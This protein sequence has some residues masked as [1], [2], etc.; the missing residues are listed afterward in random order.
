MN[1]AVAWTANCFYVGKDPPDEMEEVVFGK[2]TVSEEGVT[3]RE[4]TRT[5]SPFTKQAEGDSATDAFRLSM[6]FELINGF[7]SDIN[8]TQLSRVFFSPEWWGSL[9]WFVLFVPLLLYKV[10]VDFLFEVTGQGMSG[11]QLSIGIGPEDDP[12]AEIYFFAIHENKA[13][14][15]QIRSL[16]IA[17]RFGELPDK[18]ITHTSRIETTGDY[19]V[20]KTSTLLIAKGTLTSLDELGTMESICSLAEIAALGVEWVDEKTAK[21]RVYQNGLRAADGLEELSELSFARSLSEAIVAAKLRPNESVIRS[22]E[23]KE[24]RRRSKVTPWFLYLTNTRLIFPGAERFFLPLE[25]T[26]LTGYR[27]KLEIQFDGRRYVPH[28]PGSELSPLQS[29][30]GFSFVEAF[31][32]AR[33]A[34]AD[35]S[36][37]DGRGSEASECN[38]NSTQT[39]VHTLL[40]D[41]SHGDQSYLFGD[42]VK[43]LFTR[44]E[45]VANFGSPITREILCT[46]DA[47]VLIGPDKQ[48]HVDEV[49]SVSDYVEGGGILVLITLH[50]G[51]PENINR[52]LEPYQISIGDIKMDHE[53][54]DKESSYSDFLGPEGAPIL[55]VGNFFGAGFTTVST[56]GDADALL[57]L[58]Q[59][60]DPIIVRKSHGRGLVLV[61][62]CA[63]MFGNKQLRYLGN[64]EVLNW[65]MV[66]F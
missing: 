21:I 13:A 29:E 66:W 46:G 23:V 51:K 27:D 28:P 25:R 26:E 10:A 9:W 48:W 50:G 43:R 58:S 3:F 2:L 30:D 19:S 56:K 65:L 55:S 18:D 15:R 17:R 53:E 42:L 59:P 16:M 11:R 22:I 38:V 52:L 31:S 60:Q 44:R 35:S 64:N 4:Q 6:P 34:L 57:S 20:E 39:F 37:S 33:R 24:P 12:L 45:V 62:S 41:K 7:A 61:N 1:D 54:L 49:R 5:L 8:H 14:E 63:N 36:E 40:L 32:D 47:L